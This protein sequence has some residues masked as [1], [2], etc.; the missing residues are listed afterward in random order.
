MA[1]SLDFL[2]NNQYMWQCIDTECVLVNTLISNPPPRISSVFCEACNAHLNELD[3]VMT[4]S[5]L[6]KHFSLVRPSCFISEI[7]PLRYVV[8]CFCFVTIL[9]TTAEPFGISSCP[10]AYWS[11]RR[12]MVTVSHMP[13]VTLILMPGLC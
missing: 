7:V 1:D 9:R 2:A 11:I 10:C 12:H 5:P 8:I 4:L 13:A 6:I 3:T